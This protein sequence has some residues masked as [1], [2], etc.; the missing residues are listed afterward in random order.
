[1]FVPLTGLGAWQMSG[2][3][4]LDEVGFATITVTPS[5]DAR[6]SGHWHGWIVDGRIQDAG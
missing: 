3:A 5:I 6:S 2:A 1:L 4:A